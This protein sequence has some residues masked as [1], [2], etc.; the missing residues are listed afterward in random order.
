MRE[1]YKLRGPARARTALL[2]LYLPR[3]IAPVELRTRG[4][5]R[6]GRARLVAPAECAEPARSGRARP[7]NI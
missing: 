3:S 5:G 4:A 7:E 2:T 6:V 1:H